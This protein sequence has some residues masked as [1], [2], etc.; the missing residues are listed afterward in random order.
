MKNY[1]YFPARFLSF[2][3]LFG[4][5][6]FSGPIMAG[7]E[8]ILAAYESTQN[9]RFQGAI[10]SAGSKMLHAHTW[11]A[12]FEVGEAERARIAAEQRRE[13]RAW[14]AVAVDFGE[15]RSPLER[16]RD[17]AQILQRLTLR[18]ARQYSGLE[19]TYPAA[20]DKRMGWRIVKS[21]HEAKARTYLEEEG[22]YRASVAAKEQEQAALLAVDT[23]LKAEKEGELAALKQAQEQE[24]E[25]LR[26]QHVAAAN[27]LEHQRLEQEAAFA[28]A[29]AAAKE[30]LSQAFKPSAETALK[31][32]ELP[33]WEED[34]A[35]RMRELTQQLE[36]SKRA[37][38]AAE[39]TM[40]AKHVAASRQAEEA[41][42]TALRLHH[43]KVEEK[44]AEIREE[45]AKADKAHEIGQAWLTYYKSPKGFWLDT[46]SIRS[47]VAAHSYG[48]MEADPYYW[49]LLP[50]V[51]VHAPVSSTAS[52][53]SDMLEGS[54]AEEVMQAPLPA[55]SQTQAQRLV[56][57]VPFTTPSEEE[58]LALREKLLTADEL[59]VIGSL[60]ALAVA[61]RDDLTQT[62]VPA[63]AKKK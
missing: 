7:Y 32:Y 26:A 4:L 54:S 6:M 15:M 2:L 48:L 23:R 20:S 18:F 60:E 62:K 5:G 55:T 24:L 41:M 34:Q 45:K 12:I 39:Q 37:H 11:G 40:A 52:A 14:Q 19:E 10:T 49:F 25:A 42:Q 33:S 50:A 43:Q 61:L 1:I 22:G 44:K 17:Q 28:K 63:A 57:L 3:I 30:A 59:D 38:A 56:H 31:D 8:D 58:T 29:R 53:S 47:A 13:L 46:P 21:A 35:Q 51:T 27:A 9:E 16:L 36:E